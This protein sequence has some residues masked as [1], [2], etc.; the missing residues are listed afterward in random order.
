MSEPLT[1]HELRYVLNLLPEEA[2]IYVH[3]DEDAEFTVKSFDLR[4]YGDGK[5]ELCLSPHL[6]YTKSMTEV[7][8]DSDDE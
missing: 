4:R 3:I 2:E 8:G 6:H 1:V 7:F 5:L